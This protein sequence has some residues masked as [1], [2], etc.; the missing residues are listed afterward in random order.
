M[1]YHLCKW[2]YLLSTYLLGVYCLSIFHIA[3]SWERIFLIL[4]YFLMKLYYYWKKKWQS[5]SISNELCGCR[6]WITGLCLLV[7]EYAGT[8]TGYCC[9]MLLSSTRPFVLEDSLLSI[10][11][12]LFGPKKHVRQPT[13]PFVFEAL[14][15][16][17][18]SAFWAH[19]AH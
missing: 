18:S 9:S 5:L 15:T 8:L 7:A 17:H 19:K 2:V 16:I 3:R 11:V 4:C 13:K 10:L 1:D 12:Q 6:L 14:L